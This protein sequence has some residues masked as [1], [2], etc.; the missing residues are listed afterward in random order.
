[1]LCAVALLIKCIDADIMNGKR[2]EEKD[3]MQMSA[4]KAM[5][6]KQITQVE[7]EK[8]END[9]FHEI[10]TKTKQQTKTTTQQITARNREKERN[11]N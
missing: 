2:K 7:R 5:Q 4:F 6:R 11:K 8:V 3:T 10:K 1:M 9:V